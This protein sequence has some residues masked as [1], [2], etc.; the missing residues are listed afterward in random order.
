MIEGFGSELPGAPPVVLFQLAN[1]E[2]AGLDTIREALQI[3][4]AR[5][6]CYAGPVLYDIDLTGGDSLHL[7]TDA[8]LGIGAD[9]CFV[10]LTGL[11]TGAGDVRTRAT[12]AYKTGEQQ[13]TVAC[14][15]AMADGSVSEVPWH[16]TDQT[17][18]NDVTAAVVAGS[19]VLLTLDRALD[20]AAT[21]DYVQLAEAGG[22]TAPTATISSIEV[23]L[24]PIY[25]LPLSGRG[26]RSRGGRSRGT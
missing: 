21:I 11:Y 17:G 10:A 22:L 7:E 18:D 12:R 2:F 20:G 1:N 8:Q 26:T 4:W 16:V 23:V 19:A 25:A 24:E 6:D 9:R 15:R 14:N 3:L 5:S 13:I